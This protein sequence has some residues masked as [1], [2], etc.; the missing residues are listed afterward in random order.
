MD[1]L[2]RLIEFLI[3]AALDQTKRD[4]TPAPRGQ[5]G[6]QL[7][8]PRSQSRMRSAVQPSQARSQPLVPQTRIAAQ[9]PVYDDGG[10]RSVLTVLAFIALLII[11]ALW[12]AFTKGLG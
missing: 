8:V 11:V 9:Q 2:F 7:A 6:A 1:L 5:A 4:T 10:W 12:I 3:R